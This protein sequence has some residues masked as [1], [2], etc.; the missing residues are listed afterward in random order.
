MIK[1]SCDVCN[2][3]LTES[4]MLS[5]SVTKESGEIDS[6]KSFE[7]CEECFEKLGL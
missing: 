2:R 5:I 7:L 6:W 1:Y 4:E 3:D